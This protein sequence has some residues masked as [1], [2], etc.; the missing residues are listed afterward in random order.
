MRMSMIVAVVTLII[1]VAVV[2]V[3]VIGGMVAVAAHN[4]ISFR[5]RGQTPVDVASVCPPYRRAVGLKLVAQAWCR[6][7]GFIDIGLSAPVCEA[8]G[9]SELPYLMPF[10]PRR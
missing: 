7:P 10:I 4:E 5:S 3:I 8:I 2:G 6:Y 1:V 9:S